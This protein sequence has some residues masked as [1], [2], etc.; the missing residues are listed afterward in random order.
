MSAFSK[1]RNY[2]LAVADGV[3]VIDLNDLGN[4]GEFVG[5]IGV[6][7]SLIYLA[8]QIRQNTAQMAQNSEQ[9]EMSALESNLESANR[10]REIFILNPDIAKL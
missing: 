2:D 6:I 3:L 8:V 4:I 9:L 7:A 10:I 5:A 1:R